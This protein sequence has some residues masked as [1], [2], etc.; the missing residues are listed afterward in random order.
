[1][2]GERAFAGL[3]CEV[4]TQPSDWPVHSDQIADLLRTSSWVT[5]HTATSWLATWWRAFGGE[6]DL[7]VGLFWQGEQL[8]G[9]APLMV[10]K[11][12]FMGV[13]YRL[14]Q[15]VG[16]GLSDYADL[17]SRDDDDQVKAEMV[18]IL[19][20]EWEWDDLRLMNVRED[21]NTLKSFR[22]DAGAGYYLSIRPNSRCLY[23]DLCGS[24][25]EQ[26]YRTLSR[27][28]RHELQ[29]RK[30]KLDALGSWSLEFN[31]QRPPAE[32]FEQFR[33]LHTWRAKEEEWT[34]LYESSAFRQFF[35]E[36]LDGPKPD[37]EI[38]YSTL[39]CNGD[40]FSYTLGFVA[41]RVYYHWNIGFAREYDYVSP[42][43][44]HHQ[45]VIKECFR[46]GY[47]EFDFMR[48]DSEYKFKWTQTFRRNFRIRL[49]RK[50]GWRYVANRIQW[51]KEREPGSRT[52]RWIRPMKSIYGLLRD[53]FIQSHPRDE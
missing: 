15:F 19:L 3:R 33:K 44:L 25:F 38:L 6:H 13:P 48:G 9:Y 28:H 12:R 10:S 35:C 14:L 16:E 24:T 23:I 36:L 43:K 8:V 30:H 45:F 47:D 40:L 37:L 52:D 22:Q 42:N 26:Y 49:L 2:K 53:R 21:S 50:S 29:K 51:L 39:G 4:V 17:V 18:Q 20:N 7:R 1:V 32:L 11:Y 31:P 27:N 5:P 41:G 46:R 34:P